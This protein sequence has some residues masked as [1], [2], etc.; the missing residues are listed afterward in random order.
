MVASPVVK[1]VVTFDGD[2]WMVIYAR[3][4]GGAMEMTDLRA[5]RGLADRLETRGWLAMGQGLNGDYTL[6]A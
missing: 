5:F 3:H 1:N 4:R 6:G 2:V